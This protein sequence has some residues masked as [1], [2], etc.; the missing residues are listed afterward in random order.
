MAEQPITSPATH[1][2]MRC[3]HRGT[4]LTARKNSTSEKS[5]VEKRA[6][7]ASVGM[8]ITPV[9]VMPPPM[10]MMVPPVGLGR[11]RGRR[12]REQAERKSY[13]LHGAC[14]PFPVPMMGEYADQT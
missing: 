6:R 2:Q 10:V 11:S 8:V 9:M 4:T 1:S 12:Q 7:S 13:P 5:E 14:S 3:Q